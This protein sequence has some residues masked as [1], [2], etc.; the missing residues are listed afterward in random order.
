MIK[1]DFHKINRQKIIKVVNGGIVML[2]AFTKMQ[3]SNDTAASF[4]QESNFWWLTG[5]DEP[6]WQIIID[7]QRDK[8]W[9]VSPL[10]SGI[11]QIF[12]GSLSCD[13]AKEISGVDGVLNKDQAMNMI[14]SLAKKHSVVYTVGEP[15]RIETFDFVLNPA[16]RKLKLT[17]ERIFNDVQDCRLELS[18]LRAI[19]QPEEIAAIKRAIKLTASAFKEVKSKLPSFTH[20]YQVEAEFTYF[21]RKNGA[22]GHACEP[23]VAS[24]KNACTL[25]YDSNNSKFKKNDLLLLDIGV[26]IGGY[27]SDISRTYA[28]GQPS[29]RVVEVHKAVDSARRQIISLLHPGLAVTDYENQVD[30][31]M[32]DALDQL[33]LLS[34]IADY[35]KYFPHSISHGLGVDVHDSLGRATEFLPGMVLTVEPGIYIPEEGIGVRIEDDILIT[36]TGHQNLSA[37]LSTGL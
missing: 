28:I 29:Q 25:H 6:D 3:S 4:V 8:S 13:A 15:L 2:T 26:R 19:K 14:T 37:A 10:V 34:S 22:T 23:I 36:E 35:R 1:S 12:N 33:G 11:N 18:K 31:I 30:I 17:L 21:F 5:I 24:G 20:E 9:L 32:K 7:G 16:L 27:A